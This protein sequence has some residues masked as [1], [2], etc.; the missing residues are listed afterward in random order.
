MSLENAPSVEFLVRRKIVRDR[1]IQKIIDEVLSR[2][3]DPAI[4]R[5][6]GYYDMHEI[7][8]RILEEAYL[9]LGFGNPE[10]YTFER[11]TFAASVAEGLMKDMLRS[12]EVLNDIKRFEEHLKKESQKEDYKPEEIE[13]IRDVANEFVEHVAPIAA[14]LALGQFSLES[15]FSDEPEFQEYVQSV[16]DEAENKTNELVPTA[17]EF[18]NEIVTEAEAKVEVEARKPSI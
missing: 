3:F 6:Y 9:D 12:V 1:A 10:I 2:V 14:M 16:I 13:M 11:V 15:I 7:L 8:K 17:E 18:I 5:K 4:Q